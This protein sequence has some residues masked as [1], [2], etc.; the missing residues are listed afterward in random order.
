MHF[1]GKK[2]KKRNK[3]WLFVR[4]LVPLHAEFGNLVAVAA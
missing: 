3:I 1:S 4:L 2:N